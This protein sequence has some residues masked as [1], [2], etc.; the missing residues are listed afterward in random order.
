MA[1]MGGGRPRNLGTARFSHSVMR[2]HSGE[3]DGLSMKTHW[4]ALRSK[5]RKEEV[6]WRQIQDRG[7]E[8]Y[9]PRL[10][11]QPA[12]PRARKIKPY[13]PGYLFVRADLEELGLFTFQYMPHAIGVVCFGE[14]PG[15]VPDALIYELRQHLREVASSEAE[16][17]LGLKRGD[18]LHIH[19][20]PF[21]GYEAI[22]DDMLSGKDRVR[23]LL[24]M[25]SGR[26]V[27]VVLSPSKLELC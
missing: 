17:F 21:A 15:V 12:N 10:R 14:Q 9:Y 24:R 13:F 6:V 18:P 16:S 23:V 11:V 25:L 27:P 1:R 7:I 22:F 20:G 26:T 3:N 8:A 19:D 4:Y 2:R 5:S